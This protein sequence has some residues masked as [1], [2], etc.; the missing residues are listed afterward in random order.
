MPPVVP[1]HFCCN[2][3]SSFSS[4][5]PST[6][7]K[8]TLPQLPWCKAAGASD[9]PSWTRPTL[10]I[11]VNPVPG[12]RKTRL[13]VLTGAGHRV[14]HQTSVNQGSPT[15]LMPM[16]D[17][18]SILQ[19]PK[20]NSRQLYASADLAFFFCSTLRRRARLMCGRTPPKAIVARIRVSN[21]SSPRMASW[22]WRG[23]MR[24]TFRSL[25]AFYTEGHVSQVATA[26]EQ[27]AR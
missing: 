19:H 24:L 11:Y 14:L 25:A 20:Y 23:V 7:R 6:S 2:K 5:P 13:E 1:S 15:K 9:V 3:S 17:Y 18:P 26:W 4:A 10:G 22:R 21:S 12:R 8:L 27:L 16:R